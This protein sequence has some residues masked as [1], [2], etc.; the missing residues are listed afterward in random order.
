[1][2][3]DIPRTAFSNQAQRLQARIVALNAQH[4]LKQGGNFVISVK[5]SCIDSTATPEA[6]FASEVKTMQ[7]MQLKPKE[8]ARALAWCCALSAQLC[9]GDASRCIEHDLHKQCHSCCLYCAFAHCLLTRRHAVALGTFHPHVLALNCAHVRRH[10]TSNYLALQRVYIHS[11]P[12]V[13]VAVYVNVNECVQ[14]TLE[15]YERD[16]AV[17]VGVFRPPPKK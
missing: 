15:P 17:V 2:T 12:T 11:N 6:V 7:G 9:M 1:M 8:Q 5:A 4:F 14:I 10:P 3:V 13:T 16:H